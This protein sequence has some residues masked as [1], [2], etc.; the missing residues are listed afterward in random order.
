VAD[1]DDIAV[2][3]GAANAADRDAVMRL[4]AAFM[5]VLDSG[6]EAL[7]ADDLDERV[8]EPR[9]GA[10]EIG[11]AAIAAAAADRLGEDT[12]CQIALGDDFARIRD[13]DLAA[14]AR[15]TRI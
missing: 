10:A 13:N 5:R 8:A 7:V 1:S 2:T 12:V 4:D 9:T 14:V 11:R 15:S 3:R 6:I